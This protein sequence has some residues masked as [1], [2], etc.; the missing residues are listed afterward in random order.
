MDLVCAT[1]N[2]LVGR[3]DRGVEVSR[4]ETCDRNNALNAST[5]GRSVFQNIKNTAICSS[6]SETWNIRRRIRVLK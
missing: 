3:Y 6:A 4:D 1:K 5:L 2:G